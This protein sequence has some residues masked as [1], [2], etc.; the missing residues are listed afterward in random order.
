MKNATRNWSNSFLIAGSLLLA[1]V[2]FGLRVDLATEIGIL[3]VSVVILGLP[4]GAL[5]PLVARSAFP[6]LP[7]MVFY[8]LY[9]LVATFVI[10]E[11]ILWPSVAL[12]S[13]L[14]IAALHFGSDLDDDSRIWLRISYGL[15]V[16][17]LPCILHGGEIGAMYRTL[18]GPSTVSFI[19][20][21]Q[22]IAHAAGA[23]TLLATFW[24][25]TTQPRRCAEVGVILISGVFLPP[26][27]YFCCYFGLLHSPRHLLETASSLGLKT[28]RS[29]A[30]STIPIVA[31]T[32]SL[33]A[34]SWWMLPRYPLPER[35]LLIVFV[36]LA[37]LTVPHMLLDAYF[38]QF[39]MRDDKK[40]SL[41]QL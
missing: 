38:V 21:S 41:Q 4:H 16:I 22:W 32:L 19:L 14:L 2:T 6:H 17:T 31:A 18:A 27:L 39:R 7:R 13:F 36:G 29:V 1:L 3:A 40:L 24:K 11:W 20:P 28:I 12:G 10:F 8:A 33:A 30:A 9:I 15:A 23:T 5:D 25:G 34:V 26:L 35:M 37:A